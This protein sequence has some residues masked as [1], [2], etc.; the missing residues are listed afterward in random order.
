MPAGAG[1]E[2]DGTDGAEGTVHEL[3]QLVTVARTKDDHR[4]EQSDEQRDWGLTDESEDI[5]E[6]AGAID[7][8]GRSEGVDAGVAEDEQHR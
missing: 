7:G 8:A 4:D 2:D 5:G 6:S 1:D 3:L